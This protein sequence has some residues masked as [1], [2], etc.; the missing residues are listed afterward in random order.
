MSRSAVDIVKRARTFKTYAKGMCLEWVWR[1]VR[2]PLPRSTGL[3]DAN[4][5]WDKAAQRET[6]GTPPAGAPVY[7]R[8]GK[9]GH[10]CIS[11]GGGRVRSTDYPSN[12][13]VGEGTI[14]QIAARMGLKYS[15]WSRDYAGNPIPGLEKPVTPKRPTLKRG[16]KNAS[17]K[18]LQEG[19]LAVFPLYAQ[20]IR[21]NGGPITTFG[22][23]TESV[24][25]QFQ[26]NSGLKVTGT[27]NTAT[28]N[29]LAKYG[30]V[31]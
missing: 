28:W 13:V 24:L 23:A 14:E 1:C 18:K 20:P 27:T 17:V 9:H 26:R 8:G 21:R 3:P 11:V 2:E 31:P 15:G 25:K 7:Y 30:I 19:L 5:A 10:V 4:A 6:T 12:G 22:P 29:E 16:S